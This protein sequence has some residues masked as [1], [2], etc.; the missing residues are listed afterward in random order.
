M[1]VIIMCIQIKYLYN[2]MYKSTDDEVIKIIQL[3]KKKYY[4]RCY[5][6][7]TISEVLDF[8]EEYEIDDDNGAYNKRVFF[9]VVNL[10]QAIEARRYNIVKYILDTD[11]EVDTYVDVYTKF[12]PLHVITSVPKSSDVLFFIESED[13]LDI[14]EDIETRFETIGIYKSTSIGVIKEVICGKT[15]FTDDE[16]MELERKTREEEYKIISLLMSKKPNINAMNRSMHTALRNTIINGNLELTKLL[17]D[18]GAAKEITYD[19][20]DIFELSTL[21]KN[22]DVVRE[23]VNRYGYNYRSNNIMYN[24]CMKGCV[25]V[26][27]YLIE[28]GFNVNQKCNFGEYPLHAACRAG[29]LDIVNVLLD[30]DVNIDQKSNIEDT[31]LMLACKNQEIVKLLLERGACPYSIN[32]LGRVVIENAIE[33]NTSFSKYMLVSYIVLQENIYHDIKNEL[34]YMVTNNRIISN[35]ELRHFRISCEKEINKLKS[36]KLNY[37][38]SLDIFITSDDKKLLSKFINNK[39]LEYL[40]ATSYPIYY[41][42]LLMSINNAKQLR[43]KIESFMRIIN[44]QLQNTYWKILPLEIKYRIIY[45]LDSSYLLT[46]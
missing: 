42:Q 37:R 35:Y 15:T 5:E 45:L 46:V 19:G 27:K 31:P 3:F 40:S 25:E 10:L 9:P 33:H 7:C 22:V 14:V 44:V 1:C 30:N 16:L 26:I 2:S 24:A 38:Y 34:G 11:N 17:L 23:I 32:R 20:I 28:L 39:V 21:S 41:E 6:E 12:H 36:I 18:N 4:D 43:D 8:I 13:K 29:S